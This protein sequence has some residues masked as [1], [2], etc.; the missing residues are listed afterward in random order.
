MREKPDPY[1]FGVATN[2]VATREKLELIHTQ[3]PP[4]LSPSQV[5]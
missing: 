4:S 5:L 1:G 2:D 3:N